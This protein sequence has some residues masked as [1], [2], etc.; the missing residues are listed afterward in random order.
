MND[1]W[2]NI[3][4]LSLNQQYKFEQSGWRLSF[5]CPLNLYTQTLDDRI[6]KNKNKYTRLLVT[7]SFTVNYEWRD[8]SGNINATYYKN[9][10]D[11]G[12]IYSGYIMNNYRTFQRSYVEH[13]S[14]TSCFTTSASVGYRSALTA[15]FFRINGNYGHTRDNQIYGYEYRGATSVVHAIDKKHIQIIMLSA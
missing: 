8:W 2:Y 12:S 5:T 15:T 11:P 9:V 14:E 1:L 3:Y 10:G 6:T 7:P 13:L 4:E